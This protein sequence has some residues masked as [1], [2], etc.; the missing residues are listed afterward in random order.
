MTTKKILYADDDPRIREA[1]QLLLSC[2]GYETIE[3]SNGEEVLSR[4]DETVDLVIL[5]V[6]MPGMDGYAACSEIL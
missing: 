4:L 3:A 5:D 6:M 2:E 1:L